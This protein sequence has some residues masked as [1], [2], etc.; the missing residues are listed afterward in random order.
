MGVT[1]SYVN[2]AIG[3]RLN[4]VDRGGSFTHYGYGVREY[5][6]SGIRRQLPR[7]IDYYVIGF[8]VDGVRRGGYYSINYQANSCRSGYRY[9]RNKGDAINAIGFL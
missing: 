7:G 6:S 4:G 5:R 9:T 8:P 3:F 2:E 1:R